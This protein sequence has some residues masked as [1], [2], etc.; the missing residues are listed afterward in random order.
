MDHVSEISSIKNILT[1][2]MQLFAKLTLRV[3][4]RSLFTIVNNTLYYLVKLIINKWKLQYT[5]SYNYTNRYRLW[6][7]CISSKFRRS[8]LTSTLG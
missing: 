3:E 6:I 8:I 1:S 2:Y 7:R 5:F 4:C